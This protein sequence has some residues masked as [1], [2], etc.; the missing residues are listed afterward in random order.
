[1]VVYAKE[2]NMAETYNISNNTNSIFAIH[3]HLEKVT[4]TI[5]SAPIDTAKKNELATL[6]DQ[7]SAVLA[8]VPADKREDAEAV[9]KQLKQTIDEI[10]QPAPNKKSLAES[11]GG[12]IRTA[13]ELD[14]VLPIAAKIGSLVAGMF[15]VP[16]LV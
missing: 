2:V 16:S 3:G 6:V 13:K 9:A 4:Q 10:A 7:L 1:V 14:D 8:R 5:S 12:I 11:L 15:G